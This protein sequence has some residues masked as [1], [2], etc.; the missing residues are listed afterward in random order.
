[1]IVVGIDSSAESD[2]ALRWACE[3]AALRRVDLRAVHVVPIPWNLPDPTIVRPESARERKGALV[4]ERA[5]DRGPC[6]ERHVEGL[7][8]AGDPASLLL[9]QAEE[10]ELLVVGSRHRWLGSASA[11]VIRHSPCPVVIVRAAQKP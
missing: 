9:T 11:H 1:M 8:L 2:A 7:L 10:A 5:L 4:L 6:R 3:E